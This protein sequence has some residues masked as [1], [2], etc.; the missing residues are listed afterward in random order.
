MN[1]KSLNQ[2]TINQLLDEYRFSLEAMNRSSKTISWYLAILGKYFAF[3]ASNMLLKPLPELGAKELKAYMLYRQ[4]TPKWAK[5]PHIK[6][7]TGKLSPY[8]IQGDAR[9]IKAFWGWL[10]KEVY[11]DKNP[12]AKFPQPKVPEKP[13]N[14][15]TIEQIQKLLACIDKSNLKGAMHYVIILLLYDTGLRISEL[16]HVKLEDLNML[17]CCV[18][19]IGKGQKVRTVP[20]SKHI[21][22]E[23]LRYVNIFR[24]QL[25]PADSPYLFAT[26]EGTH[27]SVNSIQQFQRRLAKKAAL[28]GIK[29]SPHIFRH[30]FATMA[31]A[32]GANVFALKVIMGH[33]SLQ[34]TMK[35]THL[36]PQDLQLQ[37]ATF[38]PVAKLIGNKTHK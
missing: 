14:I 5:S 1:A 17:H 19:V 13:V 16:T 7:A 36:Q 22:K 24:P 3:L 9:A 23:L 33:S 12:L 10:A 32:Y 15:L 8:S 31:V 27:I 11:I 25:C 38:S 18:Q 28:D 6:K 20:F 29:V 34:T 4:K 21:R 30:S 2:L 26:S 35:Y 37:H